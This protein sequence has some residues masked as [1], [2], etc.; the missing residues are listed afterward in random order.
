M[1][2]LLVLACRVRAR[3]AG[4]RL[5]ARDAESR[6]RPGSGRS[7]RSS[8]KARHARTSTSSSTFPS[9]QVY[10][11]EGKTYAGAR[12]SRTACNVVGAGCAEAADRRLHRALARA[13][14]RRPRRLG[15]LD[16]RRAREG[17]AADRGVRRGRPDPD[18]ARRALAVLPLVRA[19][20]RLA[21]L[22]A[23]LPARRPVPPRGREAA[24]R[25][26][27]DRRRSARSRSGSSPSACAARTCCSCRSR[28]YIYGDLTPIAD[29]TRFGQAF[30]AHDARLRARRGDRLPRVAAR[31]AA[32]ARAGARRCR[33]CSLSGLSLS[34]HDAVDAGSSK[35]T[36]L[37]DWVHLSAASL[38]LGGLARARGRR[39]AGRTASS[40]RE[41]FVRFSRLA[42]VLVGLVLAA[43]TYLALVRVP[44]LRDLWTQRYGVVLLVKISLVAARGRVGCRPPLRRAAA[45]RDG[46]GRGRSRASAAAS[47]GRAMVGVAVL[48]AAA[49]LVDSKPPP[50]PVAGGRSPRRRRSTAEQLARAARRRRAPS[51]RPRGG[52]RRRRAG[53]G[54][55]ASSREVVV[56]VRRL[57][58]PDVAER[59]GVEVVH[60]RRSRSTPSHDS[61][62]KSNA[63]SSPGGAPRAARRGARRRAALSITTRIGPSRSPRPSTRSRKAGEPAGRAR[64]ASFGAK[65][66]PSG[67]AV[68][69]ALELLGRRE[70]V[71]RSCSARPCRSACA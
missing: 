5:G 70:P 44:H 32:A 51:A 56:R 19:A 43:G 69:P 62:R 28:K 16:V 11:A 71:G 42:I 18:R 10:N 24:L 8:P 21:R 33:S 37:A 1:K 48:L 66:K 35:A 65:R 38:W 34:G 50:R 26:R 57:A 15:R 20:D 17:A 25:P 68:G 7:C 53:G 49:I 12:R 41:A 3:R 52:R 13:L 30:V 2:R 36:E 55:R 46:A 27:R 40:R 47:A 14:G 45:A 4:G 22:P 6:V 31:A 59:L 63:S 67:T 58:Q 60:A 9:I 64:R 29:G 39:L 54:V 23:A 61:C